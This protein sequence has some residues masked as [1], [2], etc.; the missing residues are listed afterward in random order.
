MDD[1][2]FGLLERERRRD[3]ERLRDRE[4][5]L[6]RLA[7]SLES[8]SEHPLADAIMRAAEEQEIT[9][10]KVSSFLATAGRGI[11]GEMEG[12]T[13][14]LGNHHF[15]HE[16]GSSMPPA[17]EQLQLALKLAK[18]N[19]TVERINRRMGFFHQVGKALGQF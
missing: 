9:Y 5:D 1:L 11:E 17:L 15:I 3:R 13:Y 4:R 2:L 12:H 14:Y 7:A 10:P 16:Q 6:L 8:S 18:D 19:V